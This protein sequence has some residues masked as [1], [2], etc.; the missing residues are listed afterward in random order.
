MTHVNGRSNLTVLRASLQT[1]LRTPVRTHLRTPLRTA[2]PW[3]H[4]GRRTT[5]R[6][7][8]L[9][10]RSKGVRNGA[11]NTYST[12]NFIFIFHFL[13]HIHIIYICYYMYMYI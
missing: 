5:A 11:R 13:I 9:C 4:A 12:F 6:P 7:L 1:P 10:V 2:L 3:R 8:V